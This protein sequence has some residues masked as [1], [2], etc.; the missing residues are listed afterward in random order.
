MKIDDELFEKAK[1]LI[2]DIID[3]Y[4]IKYPLD[5]YDLAKKIGFELVP[6]STFEDHRLLL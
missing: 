1:L 2:T 4:E 5:I 3:D 6:Y